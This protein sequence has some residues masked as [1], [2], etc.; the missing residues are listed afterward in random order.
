MDRSSMKMHK[1]LVMS[2]VLVALIVVVIACIFYY[3]EINPEE[4]STTSDHRSAVV[5]DIVI[6]PGSSWYYHINYS[7]LNIVITLI[8]GN[9]SALQPMVIDDTNFSLF[10]R[11]QSYQ[12]AKE[13]SNLTIG[14]GSSYHGDIYANGS[15]LV[16]INNDEKND[17]IL[18]ISILYQPDFPVPI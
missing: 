2:L 4:R 5:S 10:Q 12:Y 14:E 1:I 11:G 17:S 7:S 8:R 15:N 9:F 16:I 3:L 6:Q 18:T 13:S